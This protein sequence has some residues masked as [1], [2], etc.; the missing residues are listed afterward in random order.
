[1][2]GS[3]S[4]IRLWRFILS[5]I[6]HM[7]MLR[8]KVVSLTSE[9]ES[10]KQQLANKKVVKN[11]S[12]SSLAPSA[13]LAR[14]NQSLRSKSNRRR[15]GQPGHPGYTLQMSMT[16]DKIVDLKS[17]F[18]SNCGQDLSEAE[19]NLQAER[20]V[21]DIP[22]IIPVTIAYRQFACTCTNC[23]N[24]Q[25][26]AFPSPVNAPVQYSENTSALAS[27]L[28]V[29]QCMPYKRIAEF[30]SSCYKIHL[31]SGTLNNLIRSFALKCECFYQQI[32]KE[33]Q[34]ASVVGSDETGVKV[35]G[36]KHWIWTWQNAENTLLF[37]SA[38]RGFEAV[39]ACFENGFKDAVL[40]TDRWAAQLKTLCRS[41]QICLAHL[42]RDVKY[43]IQVE[44]HDC[45]SQFQALFTKVFELKKVPDLPSKD[46]TERM[47][48]ELKQLLNITIDTQRYP[49]TNIFQKGM[50]KNRDNL[51][52]CLYNVDIPPDNN[53]SERA[54]RNIKVKQKVS[55]QFIAD[56]KAFCVIRSVI[57]TLIKREL[58]IFE[59]LNQIAK[60]QPE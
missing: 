23:G 55:G 56:Q 54:I 20:Q 21:V 15:G 37:A 28:S 34:N 8:G 5:L 14:K 16:P 48:T 42:L 12:N 40:I 9:V 46:V 3:Y 18:C 57:D 30:F 6:A 1:M 22:P 49:L 59:T 17:S 38:S 29:Y 52:T 32:K 35:D 24:T 4:P 33:L 19:F 41:R 11:S 10:L 13:D 36:K 25:K 51:L 39:T 7:K 47:E 60:L 31:S 26:A 50:S 45:A 43:L 58:P 27:Y 44:N 2:S 53:A